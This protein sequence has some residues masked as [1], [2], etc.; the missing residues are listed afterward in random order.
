MLDN[1][2]VIEPGP[3]GSRLRFAPCFNAAV[4]FIDRH[5]AEGRGD[6]IAIRTASE[7]VTYAELSERVAQCGNAL[8]SLGVPRG[9]GC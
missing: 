1:T 3:Y 2:V 7:A 8:L 5:L 6:K 9:G 4:A